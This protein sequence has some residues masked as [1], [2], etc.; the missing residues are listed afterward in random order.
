MQFQNDPYII[1]QLIPFIVML[2]LGLYIGSRS[3]GGGERNGLA[4]IMLAGAWWSLMSVI[5]LASPDVEWQVFWHKVTWLAA[6]M[7][8]TAWFFLAV[9]FTGTWRKQLERSRPL[10][11]G[12]PALAYLALL[13]DPWH[14]LFYRATEMVAINGFTILTPEPGPL[15]Q[16]NLYYSYAL[17]IAGIAMLVVFLFSNFKRYGSQGYA[18]IIGVLAPL[19]GN[20]LHTRGLLP[21]GFPDPT[22]ISFTI[23]GI[24]FAWAIFTGRM[25]ETVP[26]AHEMIVETLDNG[27]VVLDLDQR[28][29]DLNPAAQRILG[30]SRENATDHPIAETLPGDPVGLKE[31]LRCLTDPRGTAGKLEFR[32][33]GKEKTYRMHVSA[34][35]DNYYQITGH[36]LQFTDIS[37][38]DE[39]EK[40]LA[41]TRETM[42]AIL[43]TLHEY[44]FETDVRGYVLNINK[45]FCEH[46]GYAS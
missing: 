28:I 23:T 16:I 18:L 4:L 31:L 17:T 44:F 15:F 5:Q 29:I 39:A 21:P 30:L 12:V 19:A 33:R 36:L 26:M 8:P 10:F 37:R 43:D 13:T 34:L 3:R 1:W 2:G 11:Y 9:S 14:H 25:L 20:I 40:S 45:S 38:Q 24:A 7:L 35:R 41:N 27:I 46:L 22:P 42:T 6:L 32:P